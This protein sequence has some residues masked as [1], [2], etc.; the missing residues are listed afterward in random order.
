MTRC[1]W[2][3]RL[4]ADVPQGGLGTMTYGVVFSET[5]VLQFSARSNWLRGAHVCPFH[6]GEKR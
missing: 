1:L 5:P 4:M 6:S 2:T 3:T